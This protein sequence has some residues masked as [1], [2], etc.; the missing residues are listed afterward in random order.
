[1]A[2]SVRGSH[3]FSWPASGTNKI[4]GDA[5]QKIALMSLAQ[6]GLVRDNGSY[7]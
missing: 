3:F 6:S 7:R 1:M 4:I 5:I 2:I